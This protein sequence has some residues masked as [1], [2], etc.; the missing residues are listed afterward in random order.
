MVRVRWLHV[1]N[2]SGILLTF[3]NGET[4]Q[5]D[6]KA[7]LGESDFQEIFPTHDRFAMMQ[8]ERAG[9]IIW[10]NGFSLTGSTLYEGALRRK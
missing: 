2:G 4:H 5:V 6:V 1:I 9:G 10:A 8:I 7:I 3:D